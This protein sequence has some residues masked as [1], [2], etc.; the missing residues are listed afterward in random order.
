MTLTSLPAGF[1]LNPVTASAAT[2][3]CAAFLYLLEGAI[4]HMP[5]VMLSVLAIA[6]V[7][8]LFSRRLYF[9][10][11][12]S[13]AT[14]TL[15]SIASVLKYRTKGLIFTSTISFSPEPTHKRLPFS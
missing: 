7:L 9:S 3:L 2:L 10:I 4:N 5:F 1:L 6:T 11:Y 13:L 8:F 15:L 14:S 12:T